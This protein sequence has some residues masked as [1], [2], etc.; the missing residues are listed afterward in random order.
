MVVEAQ[1]TIVL[2][3]GVSN[4]PV[5]PDLNFRLRLD[6][7]G[8]NIRIQDKLITDKETGRFYVD[9]ESGLDMDFEIVKTDD[10]RPNDSTITI[11]NLSNDTYE[12]ISSKADAVEL[13]AAWSNDEYALMFRGYP[14][15][16]LKK[17]KDTI[18]TANQGFLKQ[19][20]NAGRRGQNDI[21]TVL[22][23]LDGKAQYEEAFMN[24]TYYGTVST[25]LILKDCIETFGIPIGTMAELEHKDIMGMQYREK[26]VKVLNGLADLLGFKWQITNGIFNLYTEKEPEK[27]YGIVLNSSNSSTPERQNDKFKVTSKTIQKANK[28]K[29]IKG[30][31]ETSVEKIYNGYMIK[32]KLLPWLNPGTYCLCDFGILQG[33]KKIYK[34]R[35]RG[36]NY[37]T[38]AETEV[39]VV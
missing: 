27:H 39:Y 38:V 8:A 13:Y 35:H 29:G 1:E 17:G 15:K 26:S 16:A 6:I 5:N 21:E 33:V 22:T 7:A 11:W 24:K 37:G 4:T 28:K 23:M 30:V 2:K 19:D 18:L 9:R 25:K 12:L 32:T 20:A 3:G 34:V 14:Y 31:K 36:N 10:N